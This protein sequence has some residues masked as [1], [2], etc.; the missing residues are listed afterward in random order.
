V[1]LAVATAY[2]D[3][4]LITVKHWNRLLDGELFATSS[5]V[6]WGALMQRT[7]GFNALKCPNCA[8]KCA[9][10]RPSPTL[11]ECLPVGFHD[12]RSQPLAAFSEH[13]NRRARSVY[14]QADVS[15]HRC[16]RSRPPAGDSS[17]RRMNARP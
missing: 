16:S 5:R 15:L 2:A 8:A 3:P 11:Y 6:D 7:F 1:A 4:P 12:V 9:F 17:R 10:L 13:R 14:V